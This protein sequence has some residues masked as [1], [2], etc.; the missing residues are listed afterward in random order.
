MTNRTTP[1]PPQIA[2]LV[3]TVIVIG[4]ALLAREWHLGK[5]AREEAESKSMAARP[6]GR[7]ALPPEVASAWLGP[8]DRR[9]VYPLDLIDGPCR[10]ALEAPFDPG[11]GLSPSSKIDRIERDVTKLLRPV[12]TGMFQPM[13]DAP[14]EP[15]LRTR[16]A[17]VET[18]RHGWGETISAY[19]ELLDR[20]IPIGAL[21]AAQMDSDTRV[22]AIEEPAQVARE[23]LFRHAN[24]LAPRVACG[25]HNGWMT[26]TST[27]AHSY[28]ELGPP[29]R[30]VGDFPTDG[31]V[32]PGWDLVSVTLFMWFSDTDGNRNFFYGL[33]RLETDDATIVVTM[34]HAPF[35]DPVLDALAPLFDGR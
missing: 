22:Y 28:A 6:R 14:E 2:F 32:T 35:R 17:G 34:N 7:R 1:R 30:L 4:G 8:P 20:S 24:L 25:N 33:R 11:P 23:R 18:I 26:R 29:T 15:M 19:R 12:V 3:A 16:D 13:M 31:G 10:E 21:L 27:P 9:G 5:R